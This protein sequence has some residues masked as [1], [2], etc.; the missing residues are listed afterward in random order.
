MNK[1]QRG[2]ARARGAAI[3]WQLNFYDFVFSG[4]DLAEACARFENLGRRFGLL[5]EYRE[6]GI[7]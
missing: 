1:Y 4:A 6:N 7:I 3:E 5:R 2:K